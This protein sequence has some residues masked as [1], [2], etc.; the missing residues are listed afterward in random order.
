MTPR[1]IELIRETFGKT[2]GI[3]DQ[4]ATLFYNKLFA[5]DPSLR[6]LFKED[7]SDQREK[8]MRVLGVVVANASRIDAV[9]PTV[10][11]LGKRHVKYGVKEENY[12]T[13]GTALLGALSD[14]LGSGFTSEVRE[15]WTQ[16]Y[17]TLSKVMIEAGRVQQHAEKMEAARSA[18]VATDSTHDVD[19]SQA[20]GASGEKS[21]MTMFLMGGGVDR[22]RRDCMGQVFSQLNLYCD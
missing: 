4:F 12:K 14:A 3:E 18:Q 10:Q 8:L 2:T 6:A 21:K 19:E 16:V 13:V 20:D 11:G 15:A 9:I 22:R 7:M 1:Q 5:L 17:V